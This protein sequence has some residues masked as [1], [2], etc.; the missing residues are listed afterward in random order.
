MKIAL[1]KRH[2]Y[3]IGGLEKQTRCIAKAFTDHG[4]S[5]T[6]ISNDTPQNYDHRPLTSFDRS[7]LQAF[8][9][10]LGID[11]L[12]YQSHIRAGNGVH[13]AYLQT[14]G[15]ISKLLPKHRQ[16]LALE[17]AALLEPSLRH[18]IT[19]SEMV[20]REYIEHYGVDENKVTALHNGVEWKALEKPYLERLEKSAGPYHFLFV[21]NDLK[22]K[23]LMPLLHALSNLTQH[24]WK[25][26][27]VGSDKRLNAFQTLAKALGIYPHIHFAGKQPDVYP[28]YAAADCLVLPS[29][30]DPFA[31]VTIEALA[32]G[33][34][35]ITS[36]TNGGSE[37]LTAATGQIVSEPKA[38][39]QAL[40]NAISL[41]KKPAV[42]RASVQH[43]D[44]DTQLKTFVNLCLST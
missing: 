34:H 11:R 13:A 29:F 4:C 6:L 23:G 37:V 10:T 36:P 32:A 3:G 9:I 26:T 44:F 31:N 33:L 8:D 28:Y 18:I 39:C 27:V 30:Y 17:R 22:R 43:L 1:L 15:W 19:N 40:E 41:P 14:K 42:C 12:P 38:L 16:E 24:D 2:L 7:S 20:R 35:V 25:L 21:G 5:V